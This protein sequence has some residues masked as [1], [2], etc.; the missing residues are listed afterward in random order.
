MKRLVVI[1]NRVAPTEEGQAPTGGLAVAV[2]AALRE[3]GGIW[4][5]WNGDVTTAVPEAPEMTQ[6]DNLTYATVGLTR[7]D[8]LEYYIGFSNATLW[9]LFHYRLDLAGFKRR[10]YAGYNRVNQRFARYLVPLLRRDDTIWVH[11]YHLIPMAEE[12]RRMGAGQPIGFFL[13]TPFP[14][15]QVLVALP[16][17]AALV[18]ALFS[19]DLIGFQTEDDLAAFRDYVVHEAGGTIDDSGIAHAFGKSVRAEAYPIGIDFANVVAMAKKFDTRPVR[20]EIADRQMVIGVDRLDYSKGLIERFHAFERMLEQ[21]PETHRRVFFVQIAPPSRG[22]VQGYA[23]IRRGLEEA[24]GH[25]NGRFAD[26]DWTPI[27]YLNKSFE[28]DELSGFFRCAACGLVTP[29]RDG[30]NLV[31]KEYV[32]SQ[33]EKSPGVLVLSRFAGAARELREALIVNPHDSDDVAGALGRALAMPI[34]ERRRRWRAMM[35]RLQTHDV[36]AWRNTFL[37]ALGEAAREAEAA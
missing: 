15:L 24:A 30:M 11:D 8:Y 33:D 36:D 21:H 2:H 12:M 3:T 28:R 19:Y 17:H 32:A 34:E 1:S 14:A 35:A 27:R 6:V 18:R 25:I 13:H 23:E 16:C 26:F 7:R 31:A 4:F 9:P 22:S 5:G 10:E 37:Q 20:E 29:L